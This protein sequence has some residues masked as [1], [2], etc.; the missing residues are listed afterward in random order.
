MTLTIEMVDDYFN[1]RPWY[2]TD[3]NGHFRANISGR[4]RKGW[5][6]IGRFLDVK[7]AKIVYE[8]YQQIINNYI[9]KAEPQQPEPGL[10]LDMDGNL[11][12]FRPKGK[13]IPTQESMWDWQKLEE[14]KRRK[15]NHD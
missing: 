14:L 13:G 2:W 5:K 3:G 1:Q 11:I 15:V 6:S 12:P 10:Q 7:E 4:A 9:P 8:R